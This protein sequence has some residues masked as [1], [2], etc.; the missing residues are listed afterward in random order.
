MNFS[1]QGFIL[2]VGLI[3]AVVSASRCTL[4]L[5]EHCH[6]VVDCNEAGDYQVRKGQ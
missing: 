5:S 3:A 2:A 6:F 1:S 4:G